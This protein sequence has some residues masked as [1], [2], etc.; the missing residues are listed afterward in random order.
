[1]KASNTDWVVDFG[2]SRVKLG[3]FAEDSEPQVLTDQA[4]WEHAQW[5]W[6][7][8]DVPK[9]ILWTASGSVPKAWK[10]WRSHLEEVAGGPPFYDLPPDWEPP[11]AVQIEGRSTLG[12]DRLAHAAAVTARDP[13][14]NWMVVDAGTILTCD[15]VVKGC[16]VGGTLSPGMDM[17]FASMYQGTARLPWLA[18]WRDMMPATGSSIQS[19]STSLNGVGSE[20]VAAMLLGVRDG[21][22]SEITGRAAQWAQHA[23]PL[24]VILT[25]GDACFLDLDLGGSIFADDKLTLRGYHALLQHL[26]ET[27]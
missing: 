20:T 22:R 23:Q 8:R 26:A 24:Q 18:G 21:M 7:W 1:M 2:N 3:I 4:A 5:P 11:F 16:F 15:L 14:A 19:A 13:S 17:R 10:N 27:N 9:R 12:W 25:G 6:A